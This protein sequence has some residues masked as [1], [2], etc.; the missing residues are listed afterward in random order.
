[1]RRRS[2]AS[3]V[4]TNRPLQGIAS[5][6]PLVPMPHPADQGP[7]GKLRTGK[8]PPRNARPAFKD[9]PAGYIP[10]ALDPSL[11]I[12]R[13]LSWLEFNQRVLEEARDTRHPCSNARSS[14][15]SSAR[16]STNSS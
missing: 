6:C 11:Y 9:R 5:T 8:V 4:L 7:D 2:G 12:N 15:R 10:P 16:T 3:R 14:C 1:M 13:E